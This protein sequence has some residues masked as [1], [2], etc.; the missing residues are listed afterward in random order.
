MRVYAPGTPVK[1]TIQLGGAD[2]AY[3][4]QVA[5]AKPG[6]SR[7]QIRGR[8]G[9]RFTELSPEALRHIRAGLPVGN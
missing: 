8:V 7:V 2:V 5:W 1:G 6:D 3:E 9:V 4:G